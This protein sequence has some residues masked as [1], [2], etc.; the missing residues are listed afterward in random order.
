LRAIV[1]VGFKRNRSTAVCLP[2]P[3]PE[4][5]RTSLQPHAMLTTSVSRRHDLGPEHVGRPGAGQFGV[6]LE[7]HEPPA[8]WHRR[9]SSSVRS[10]TVRHT[11]RA[12]C[13][14]P[15]VVFPKTRRD[16]TSA[17]MMAECY[18]R[19]TRLSRGYRSIQRILS[20][21]LKRPPDPTARRTPI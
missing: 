11:A 10:R 20:W 18:C 17:A 19:D 1:A 15:A 12:A 3:G 16:T 21:L 9:R 6:E 13:P 5:R 2:E 14:V 4:S 8:G 7:R